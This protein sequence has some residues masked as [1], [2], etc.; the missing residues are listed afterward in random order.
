[1]SIS[2]CALGYAGEPEEASSKTVTLINPYELEEL[3]DS[4]AYRYPLFNGISVSVDAFSPALDLFGKDYRSYEAMVT[5]DLHHRFMPQV[6]AGIGNCD[7]TSDDGLRF[8]SKATPFF[9]MGMVYNFKYNDLHGSDFYGAFVR[10]GFAHTEANLSGIT[11]T[12]GVWP[13]YGPKEI[14]GIT[15][16]SHWLEIGGMIKVQVARHFSM[17]WDVYFKPFLHKGTSKYGDAYYIP[18]YGTS[19]NKLGFNFHLYYDL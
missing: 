18:G 1:M 11:Y 17:G 4:I 6:A 8:K 19:S 13:D 10:Y 5:L 12:D 9:K 2:L 14:D 16:N 7:Y 3:P 15:Y